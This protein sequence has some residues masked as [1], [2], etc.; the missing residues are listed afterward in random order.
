[1]YNQIFNQIELCFDWITDPADC[2]GAPAKMEEIG[3]WDKIDLND[4]EDLEAMIKLGIRALE[5]SVDREKE[6]NANFIKY[7]ISK[8]FDINA[9]VTGGDCLLLQAV[10]KRLAPSMIQKLVEL[11]A[12]Q[13][14][15]NSDGDN[16]LILAAKQ[17]Y[18]ASEE[19]MKGELGIY[20]VEHF[21]QIPLDNSDRYGITP[22]MYAAMYDHILLA[23]TLIAHG[24]DVNAAGTPPEGNNAFWIKM[25]GVTP[26]ALACRNG[27]VEIAKLLLEAGADE[28]IRDAKGKAPIFSLLRYPHNFRKYS[29]IDDPIYSRKCEIL[30]MLKEL[31]LTDEEGYTAL[32]RSMQDSTEPFDEASA[33]SNNLPI[34][35]AL[36]K[37]GANVEA[38]GNDGRRPLHL[39]VEGLG[40]VH[41]SLIK[42]GVQL[43][44]QDNNGDTPLLIACQ[45][46]NE[47]IV[48][49]LIKAGADVTIQNNKGKTAMDLCTERGFTSAI[50]LMMGQ[51]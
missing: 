13:C 36:I 40:D 19:E 6:P 31:D 48:R 15:E 7:L 1:M 41:K 43:N 20:I 42:A 46:C 8:G 35:Q 16:L 9:T 10:K 32:M 17:E 29:R 38:V 49:Y 44:T 39:A 24:A 22:L 3:F 30:S 18:D 45:R 33:Y 2:F 21:D 14:V 26:L 23:K 11:G 47:T 34:T 27:S 5:F 25:D 28:T 51:A 4:D 37:Q 12:D 50:D